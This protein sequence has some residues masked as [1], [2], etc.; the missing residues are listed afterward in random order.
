MARGGQC[1]THPVRQGFHGPETGAAPA[2]KA[3]VGGVVTHLAD[4]LM[5]GGILPDDHF[6]SPKYLA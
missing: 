3:G 5:N 2:G 6:F 1:L 4:A